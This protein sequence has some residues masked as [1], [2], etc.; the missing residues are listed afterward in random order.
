MPIVRQ[1]ASG[2]VLIV[3]NHACV[4]AS[5]GASHQPTYYRGG[6]MKWNQRFAKQQV[7]GS[8][9]NWLYEADT[10]VYCCV[11]VIELECA[12]RT[13]G[14]HC[15]WE[16]TQ[17]TRLKSTGSL[18]KGLENSR[19]F[20]CAEFPGKILNPGLDLQGGSLNDL[21]VMTIKWQL[22]DFWDLFST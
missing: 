16:A 20:K 1:Y 2:F 11:G 10:C 19:D 9:G 8:V 17:Y 13:N 15:E 14:H 12:Q 18:G 5:L 22:K 21:C 6:W 4:N 7:W 3:V